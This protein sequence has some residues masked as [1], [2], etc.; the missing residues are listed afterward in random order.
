MLADIR[1]NERG[2][3]HLYL[4]DY[5]FGVKQKTKNQTSWRCTGSL[6]PEIG[7][8]MRCSALVITRNL[9]G[10]EMMKT[11]DVKHEHTAFLAEKKAKAKA[12]KNE[13]KKKN[14]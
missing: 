8:R 7:K 9:L 10:Y 6:Y 12:K 2:F 1:E 3:K 14:K 5:S 4:N 13:K 11:T